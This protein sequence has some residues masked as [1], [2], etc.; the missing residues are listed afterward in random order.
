MDARTYGHGDWWRRF[1][2]RVA[3][4]ATWKDLAFLL[5]QLPVGIVA[6]TVT[7]T[8]LGVGWFRWERSRCCS[9]FPA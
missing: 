1:A 8:V 3:D 7:V 5:L 2:A 4:P 9:A 6:F